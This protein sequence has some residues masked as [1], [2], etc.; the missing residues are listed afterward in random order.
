MNNFYTLMDAVERS[1]TKHLSDINFVEFS[2]SMRDVRDAFDESFGKRNGHQNLIIYLSK[3][4]LELRSLRKYNLSL[5]YDPMKYK[6][7]A[8]AIGL[9]IVRSLSQRFSSDMTRW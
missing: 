7:E 8:Y 6:A 1:A 3:R 2:V 5:W 4:E 9:D